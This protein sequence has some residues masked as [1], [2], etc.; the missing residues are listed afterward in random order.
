MAPHGGQCPG[1]RDHQERPIDRFEREEQ[2]ALLPLAARPYHSLL[3]PEG[4]ANR[5]RR[6]ARTAVPQVPVERRPLAVYARIAGGE[7]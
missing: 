2:P 4:E 6:A 7:R 1:A 3:L 5:P